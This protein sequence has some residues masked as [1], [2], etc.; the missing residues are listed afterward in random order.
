[1]SETP[2]LGDKVRI[3]YEGT[4]VNPGFGG[5]HL[6]GTLDLQG[7]RTEVEILERADDPSKDLVGTVREYEPYRLVYVKVSVNQWVRV[8]NPSNLS[9]SSMEFTRSIGVVPGSPADKP[10]YEYYQGEF[11]PYRVQGDKV[12]YFARTP[13]SWYP[14]VVKA[15]YIRT[16]AWLDSDPTDGR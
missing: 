2:K 12:E 4:A 15:S 3:T 1:M 6:P 10:E 7:V 13:K 9:D 5:I 16:L 8:G 14:S 11:S